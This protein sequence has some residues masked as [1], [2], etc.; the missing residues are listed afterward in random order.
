MA[1]R[2]CLLLRPKYSV[3]QPLRNSCSQGLDAQTC[4][5]VAGKHFADSDVLGE[6]LGRF[7]GGLAY[8]LALAGSVHDYLRDPTGAQGVPFQNLAKPFL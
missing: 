5:G 6:L 1:V 3:A 4:G 8:D 2:P 7:V